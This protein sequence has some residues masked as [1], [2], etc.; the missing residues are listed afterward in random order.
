MYTLRPTARLPLQKVLLT[1]SS[2][3]KQ[4]IDLIVDD[5][6]AHKDV[7]TASLVVTGNDP[8]PVQ[9]SR[10]VVTRREDMSITHEESDT[11]I[12]R[13]IA[14][15]G[16]S[17]VLV[18]ADDTDVFVLLCHFV[19]EGDITLPEWHV[20]HSVNVKVD[21]VVLIKRPGNVSKQRPRM[22]TC[23]TNTDNSRLYMHIRTVYN[24]YVLVKLK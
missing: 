20:H 11:M 9:I 4:L 19:F 7:L 8:V 14:Y 23:E 16:A 22:K 3:K 24:I 15:V 2:N 6:V 12:I 5:L 18:V 21:M 10:G 13:Q 1:V 17:E